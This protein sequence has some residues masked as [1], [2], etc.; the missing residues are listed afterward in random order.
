MEV[1]NCIPTFW[2]YYF[3][4]ECASVYWKE[5][6]R[7]EDKVFGS[8]ESIMRLWFM[9][10]MRIKVIKLTMVRKVNDVC[11]ECVRENTIH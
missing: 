8:K 5:W 4:D 3:G 7:W 11:V 9:L 6:K 2:D 10:P 1:E